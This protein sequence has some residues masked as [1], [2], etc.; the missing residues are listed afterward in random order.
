LK[1]C[2]VPLDFPNITSAIQSSDVSNGDTII[3][4]RNPN[5]PNGAYKEGQIIV[6]ESL[7]IT[8]DKRWGEVVVDGMHIGSVFSVQAN[9][10]IIRGF[11]IINSSGGI[12]VRRGY[13]NCKIVSN[14]IYA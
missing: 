10:V 3:V 2:Y 6:N 14:I 9:D 11:T 13:R 4:L 12:N 1:T 8:A 7:N 5:D